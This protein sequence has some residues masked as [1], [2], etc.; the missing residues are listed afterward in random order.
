MYSPFDTHALLYDFDF[1]D[2]PRFQVNQ[3]M[4]KENLSFVTTRQT[5]EPFSIIATNLICSQHKIAAVYD[6]S[7][8][9]PL[10][11]YQDTPFLL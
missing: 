9:I 3:H 4:I 1:I 6:R 11:L 2:R 8:F 10:Y 7:Y 5:I